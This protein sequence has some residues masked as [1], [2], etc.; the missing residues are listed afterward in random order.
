LRD[1][2]IHKYFGIDLEIIWD[3]IKTK[4]PNLEDQIKRI[5]S[6]PE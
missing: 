1:I 6:E 4:A 3:I 5:L 2:L